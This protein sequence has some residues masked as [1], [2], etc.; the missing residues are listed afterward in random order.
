MEK[1]IATPLPPKASAS[2]E[3]SKNS[4]SSKNLVTE[5]EENIRLKPLPPV[6]KKRYVF[7]FCKNSI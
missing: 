5:L 3:K 6:L 7:I 2:N 1:K 4:P